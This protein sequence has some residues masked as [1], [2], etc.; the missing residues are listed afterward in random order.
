MKNADSEDI[1]KISIFN[2]GTGKIEEVDRI[3]K[4]DAEW[5]KVLTSEQHRIT[6]QKGT[7]APFT[8]KCE[9]GKAGGIY[10]C[11][12]CGTDLF[13]VDEKF[14]SGTGWPSFWKPVFNLNIKEE[15]DKSMGMDRTE[16][17]CIRCDAHLGHVFEDGPPPTNKR[18][19]INAAALKFLPTVKNNSKYERAI[20]AAGCFWGAEEAFRNI[21]GVV[22]TRVGYTGGKTED[23]TYESVCTDKTGHAEAVEVEYDASLVSYDELLDTFWKIHDPTTL[24]RQGPDIG[25]QYRSAIFY[26]NAAQKASAIASKEKL[27]GSGKYKKAITTEIIP[28]V[29]FYLAEEYHQKYHMKHGGQCAR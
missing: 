22:S 8:G 16:I 9:I 14:E 12:C 27:E 19:C 24:N 3:V 10:K 18:Y 29:G 4:S 6:R 28:A 7:E 11:V 20:F 15:V 23:P 25:T 26:D 5:K 13:R 2:T 21:K 1:K 17:L